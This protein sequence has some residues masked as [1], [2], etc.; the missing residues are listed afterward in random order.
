MVIISTAT[1]QYLSPRTLLRNSTLCAIP[2]A[3]FSLLCF[4][5]DTSRKLGKWASQWTQRTHTD[6]H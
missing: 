2:K 5:P 3:T 4:Y 1:S 6:F